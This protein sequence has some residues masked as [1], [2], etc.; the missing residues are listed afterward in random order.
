MNIPSYL[1]EAGE[2]VSIQC[3]DKAKKKISESLEYTK[4]RSVPPW[5]EF[6][7]AELKAKVLRL[8]EK[9]DILHQIE[10]QLIVELYSK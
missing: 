5:L 1:I 8:P 2:V 6:V 7:P 4:D 9:S 3:K 10:E